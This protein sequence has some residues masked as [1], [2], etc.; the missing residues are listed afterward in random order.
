[1]VRPPYLDPPAVDL[2]EKLHPDE[3]VE[4]EGELVLGI[5]FLSLSVLGR[6]PPLRG[7]ELVVPEARGS[8][9]CTF[10]VSIEAQGIV[11]V[12]GDG[13]IGRWPGSIHKA[14]G[15]GAVEGAGG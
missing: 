15:D 12:G 5:E 8:Q 14:K 10:I 3:G 1:M 13:H 4:E 11:L 7:I 6:H 2:V 9:G